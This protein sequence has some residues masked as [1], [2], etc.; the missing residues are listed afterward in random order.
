MPSVST[1]LDD[2]LIHGTELLPSHRDRSPVGGDL[3]RGATLL[4]SSKGQLDAASTSDSLPVKRARL[5][6]TDARTGKHVQQPNHPKRLYDSALKPEA[7]EQEQ[8]SP[9]T[10]SQERQISSDGDDSERQLKR[11]RLTRKNLALFDKM[12]KKKVPD[13]TDESGSTKTTSTTTSG[14]V[15]KAY[16]NNILHPH[17]SKP[18]TNSENIRERHAGSRKT[19]SP[20]EPEYK[21][22]ANNIGKAG[23]EATMVVEVSGH[24][25]KNYDDSGYQRAFNR[26]FTGLPKDVGF[27]N[28]LSAPQPDFIEGLE[29][30]E[31]RPFPVADHVSGAALYKG[32]PYSLALPHLAGEWKGPDGNMREAELQSAYDGAAMVYARNQALAYMGKADPPGHAEVTTF[33][34]NGTNLNFYSHYAM[35]SEDGT[36]EYHQYAHASANVMD[37]QPGHND[38]RRGLRNTQDHARD[39]S[40]ALRDQL[41][42]HWKQQRSTLPSITQGTPTDA[43][44]ET[45]QYRDEADYEIIEQPCQPT[46]AAST[47]PQRGLHPHS[48]RSSHNSSSDSHKRKA[49]SS[50]TSSHGSPGHASKYR[51][52]WKKDPETAGYYHK[53]SDSRVSWLDDDNDNKH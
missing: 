35:K 16:K 7:E 20:T 18:P 42:E 46:A 12:G 3:A 33:T 47:K 34:T 39:Q 22:Y 31:Y 52:Y 10:R 25:L 51:S 4:Q 48:S 30:Q 14:F 44:E 21:R 13:S 38:G 15:E 2:M 49:S 40:Y 5:T 36:V 43:Y 9:A 32:D 11:S 17:H 1:D 26:A 28:G 23:N 45:A 50:Q 41:K 8:V 6:P 53:H 27:N 19:A 24:M 37:T 29:K